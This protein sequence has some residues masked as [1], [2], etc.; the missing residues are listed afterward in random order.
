[1]RL[2]KILLICFILLGTM[3]SQGLTETRGGL[4]LM[5]DDGYPNW[6]STIAPELA[7]VGGVATGYVC[8]FRVKSEKLTYADLHELQDCYGWEIGSHTYHHFNRRNTSNIKAC[9]L[10]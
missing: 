2:W 9:P 4:V 3:P 10:G 1:M 8:V 7:R 6:A 5:F